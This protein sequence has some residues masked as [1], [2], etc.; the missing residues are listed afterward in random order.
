MHCNM[1]NAESEPCRCYGIRLL[2][3]IPPISKS[4][5]LRARPSHFSF[6]FP[7]VSILPERGHASPPQIYLL[8][9]LSLL[10]SSLRPFT[11]IIAHF[12]GAP[13]IGNQDK[14]RERA[15][16]TQIAHIHILRGSPKNLEKP[17]QSTISKSKS[18]VRSPAATST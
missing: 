18:P 1:Q 17:G 15:E 10:H 4:K 5:R 8:V 11:S 6:T 13:S 3:S 7:S 14:A 16:R 9:A 12:I 2:F